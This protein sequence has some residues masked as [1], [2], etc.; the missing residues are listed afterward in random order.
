MPLQGSGDWCAH[1]LGRWPRLV[2]NAPLALRAVGLT[3]DER[4]AGFPVRLVHPVMSGHLWG[5][6]SHQ[7]GIG[8]RAGCEWPFGLREGKG[9]EGGIRTHGTLTG[10]PV[11]KTG[12]INRSTTSPL[13]PCGG[14]QDGAEGR[15]GKLKSGG[16]AGG[17]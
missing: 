14:D 12:A 9:G 5:D 6:P 3:R 7:S 4:I 16:M 2:W 8:G 15:K 10:T 13:C 1:N 17:G 11:F